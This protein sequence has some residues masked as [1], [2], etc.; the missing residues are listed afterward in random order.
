[1]RDSAS[2]SVDEMILSSCIAASFVPS[3]YIYLA[4]DLNLIFAITVSI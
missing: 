2:A 3:R 1:M 4:P